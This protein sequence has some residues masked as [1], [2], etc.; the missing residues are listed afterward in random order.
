MEGGYEYVVS[1]GR[2]YAPRHT[3]GWLAEKTQPGSADP[4]IVKFTRS[5]HCP[6]SRRV[7]AAH[8]NTKNHAHERGRNHQ[9]TLTGEEHATHST[10]AKRPQG[11]RHRSTGRRVRSFRGE[12][13]R[14]R[15]HTR[16]AGDA[17]GGG[18]SSVSLKATRDAR[19]D[20]PA[21]AVVGRGASRST[22]AGFRPLRRPLPR[23]SAARALRDLHLL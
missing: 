13:R 16:F 19:R 21:A 23:Q 2:G 22:S 15:P 4:R 10:M 20:P 9:G 11:K 6:R 5:A 18:S 17:R 8:E 3:G 12:N 1:L 7:S 14:R